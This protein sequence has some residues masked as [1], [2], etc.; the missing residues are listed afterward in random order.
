VLINRRRVV[1]LGIVAGCLLFSESS[2]KPQSCGGGG[3]G[4]NPSPEC[5]LSSD[6][7]SGLPTIGVKCPSQVSATATYKT[8][9]NSVVGCVFSCN[10]SNNTDPDYV[11]VACNVGTVN[12]PPSSETSTFV[13]NFNASDHKNHTLAIVTSLVAPNGYTSTFLSPTIGTSCLD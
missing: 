4:S 2:V 1:S 7:I 8:V 6:T 12:S 10:P 5:V 11:K 3:G 9:T 13:A